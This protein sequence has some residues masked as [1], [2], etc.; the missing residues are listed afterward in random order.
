MYIYSIPILKTTIDIMKD[1]QKA[2]TRK[3]F[4]I[5]N[6]V[7]EI[8]ENPAVTRAERLRI[9]ASYKRIVF[10][11]RFSIDIPRRAFSLESSVPYIKEGGEWKPIEGSVAETHSALKDLI[12]YDLMDDDSIDE[13]QKYGLIL[14]VSLL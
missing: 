3:L 4:G 9:N 7:K 1:E 2:V 8:E 6:F 12:L 10:V 14:F 13:G 5:S 11:E